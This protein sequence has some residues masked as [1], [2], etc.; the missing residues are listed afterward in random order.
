MAHCRP[1][2]PRA[3]VILGLLA[4]CSA[5][6]SRALAQPSVRV[7]ATTR[8]E[9]RAT[10]SE[11]GLE[12][13]G[14][15]LDDLGAPLAGRH[16]DVVIDMGASA[17]RTQTLQ[18]SQDGRFHALLALRADH[19]RTVARFAGDTQYAGSEQARDADASLSGVTLQFI[20]PR[21]LRLDLDAPK[22][23]V[24]LRADSAS[25]GAGLD[26][27]LH[28]E[29]GHQL[30]AGRTDANAEF[31]VELAADA[32]GEPGVGRLIARSSA[33]ARRAPA[34]A[35]LEVLRF[36]ATSLSLAAR[37]DPQTGRVVLEGVLRDSRSGLANK[38]VGLF[39]GADH[40][41]T[42]WTS[43]NGAF[44]YATAD[45]PQSE[46]PR[47]A[48]QLQARFDTDAPWIGASRSPVVV[49]QLH[50]STPPSPLWLMV[51]LALCALLLWLL[52]RRELQDRHEQRVSVPERGA[53][54]HP[55]RG[56]SLRAGSTHISGDVRDATSGRP[57]PTAKLTLQTTGHTLAVAIDAA[58]RFQSP[59]LRAG[60]WTFIIEAPGYATLS[61]RVTVPHRGEWSDVQVSLASLRS[62]ALL[63]YRPA[64]L[65]A[66]P[67]LE[68]WECWT[69]R[70][71]L[72]NALRSGLA[73]TSFVQL[74]E[75]VERAAYAE[76]P[77]NANDLVE[78]QRVAR[79][80]MDDMP[81][82]SKS[83]NQ[84]P[85]RNSASLRARIP[86]HR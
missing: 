54:F 2:R 64:A 28:D 6:G 30:A 38:A 32:L 62:A 20:E 55:S 67:S 66:L 57:V 85:S 48:L 3:L 33:D 26:L 1:Q 46:S 8:V 75:Q 49:L 81:E 35:G 17:R 80:A 21:S 82:V 37:S 72:D 10:P 50:R 40:L 12:L 84:S 79:A 18:T 78:I 71:T 53:G 58:A 51:P 4:V 29:R 47:P 23:L 41:A 44:R 86:H 13:D 52:S 45:L 59:E 34:E 7:R 43:Q 73:S 15:L 19:Y 36:R 42:I 68:L 60:D 76:Q 16:L 27:R 63:A 69:A 77:P 65:R 39:L 11:Q 25:G 31:R 14:S 56:A 61:G 74:T 22:Q 5:L 83:E 9:L 24:R 70:E